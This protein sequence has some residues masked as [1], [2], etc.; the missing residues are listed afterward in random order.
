MQNCPS[1]KASIPNDAKFCPVCG[2]RVE[3]VA[4][5]P[6]A[7][8][9][10][11]A[12]PPGGA[13][14]LDGPRAVA[15]RFMIDGEGQETPVGTALQAKDLM[16]QGA[17]VRLLLV[18]DA[19]L[20]NTPLVDRPLREWKQLAKIGTP[21]VARV[22]DQGR[23]DDG[24]VYV[25]SEP[26]RGVPLAD[27]VAREGALSVERVRKIISQLGEALSEAQKVGVIHRDVAPRNIYLDGD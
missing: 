3:P 26:P 4:K 18:A 22:V 20:P 2:S 23:L 24:K 1:C 9:P 27:I 10:A 15:G 14:V 8:K 5:S 12:E 17:P 7:A 11:A 25:A 19:V 21:R 6:A 16:N 13:T